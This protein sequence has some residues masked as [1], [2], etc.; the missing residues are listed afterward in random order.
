[1]TLA[2]TIKAILSIQNY[3]SKDVS[4]L[5]KQIYDSLKDKFLK[6]QPN[7][8]AMRIVSYFTLHSNP[9]KIQV[10]QVLIDELKNTDKKD[11]LAA[12]VLLQL[13]VKHYNDSMSKAALVFFAPLVQ[14]IEM[15]SSQPT[16][17]NCSACE[18]ALQCI[19]M[20]WT[21]SPG[22]A[23][24]EA[25]STKIME[26]NESESMDASEEVWQGLD[27]ILTVLEKVGQSNL[28]RIRALM[29]QSVAKIEKQH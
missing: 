5:F 1:L 28:D 19:Q 20:A 16:L 24:N 6:K 25:S 7:E 29:I 8:A 17:L 14:L 23:T 21:A 10:Q 3:I 9:C 22:T 27:T 26:V 12:V 13:L 2:P 15:R 11:Q 4:A 18:L